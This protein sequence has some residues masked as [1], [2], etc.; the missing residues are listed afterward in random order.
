[1]FG[2]LSSQRQ[3]INIFSGVHKTG[4]RIDYF[5]SPKTSLQNVIDCNIGKHVISDHAPVFLRLGLSNQIFY[6]AAWKF[7]PWLIHDP[8]LNLSLKNK[9][10][11]FLM[12][13]KTPDVSPNLLWDTAKAY[14]RGLIISYVSNQ[15]KKQLA[16]Q[17]KLE[18]TLHG[19]QIKYICTPQMD[20]WRRIETVKTSLEAI[21]TNKA[22]KS[23]FFARQR[24]YEFANK[25][26]IC[27]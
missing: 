14:I 8:N 21:L 20:F 17:R 10:K 4:S 3:R 6:P 16:D 15:K 12:E 23:V 18:M 24:M 25:P 19:L 9:F 11:L 7:K 5:F 1:M 22:E 2:V 26:A 13:N 27:S